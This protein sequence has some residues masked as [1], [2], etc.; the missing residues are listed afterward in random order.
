VKKAGN[1]PHFKSTYA[2]LDDTWESVKGPLVENK[3]SVIMFPSVDGMWFNLTWQGEEVDEEKHTA[4]EFIEGFM[5][6]TNDGNPQH[7]GSSISYA[8]RYILVTVLNLMTGE[9]DDGN[10]ASTPIEPPSTESQFV[11]CCKC[12]RTDTKEIVRNDIKYRVCPT[13]YPN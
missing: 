9:D 3:L 11:K 13:H 4:V 5:P 6:L 2:T 10:A 12:E 7:L 8:R 1:N